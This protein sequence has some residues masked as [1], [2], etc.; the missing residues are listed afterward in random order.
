[1]VPQEL[2]DLSFA[3]EY[4]PKYIVSERD[5]RNEYVSTEGG[6]GPPGGSRQTSDAHHWQCGYERQESHSN[7]SSGDHKI[8]KLFFRLDDCIKE[9]VE[10][11]DPRGDNRGYCGVAEPI[12]CAQS[13]EKIGGT[14]AVKKRLLLV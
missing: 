12:S 6:K 14:R 9:I 5:D 11:M 7:V 10:I 3:R 8:C 13:H 4:T 1:M 2:R